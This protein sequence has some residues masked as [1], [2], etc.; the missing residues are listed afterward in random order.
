ME[1][2]NSSRLKIL[3]IDDEGLVQE[4]ISNVLKLAGHQ[5]TVAACGEEGI[6]CFQKNHYDLVITDLDMPGM[7]G[8]EV[9][10]TIK[11]I[12]PTVPV[13]MATGWA[14]RIEQEGLQGSKVDLLLA[15]PFS[16]RGLRDAVNEA[17]KLR[18]KGT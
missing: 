4:C 10:R 12:N 1:A 14:D 7:D 2:A 5:V 3:A 9:A 6:A 17:L 15:K 18:G 11:R 8:W 13:I 16:V